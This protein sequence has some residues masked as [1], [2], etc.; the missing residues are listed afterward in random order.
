MATTLN[1][2][3]GTRREAE[4]TVERLVQ[5]FAIDRADFFITTEG[6]A[7]SAGEQIAGSDKAA[8]EPTPKLR[9]DA[10]LLGPI[11]VSVDIDD[12]AKVEDVRSTFSEFNAS[13]LS[14][15]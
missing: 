5:E 3:F 11:Q 7:N 8:G 10:A 12:D 2:N 9:D 15:R 6:D 14:E 13:D 1:A 4:M